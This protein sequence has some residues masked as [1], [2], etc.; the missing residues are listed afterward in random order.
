MLFLETRPLLSRLPSC[1]LFLRGNIEDINTAF[2]SS[3]WQ[4]R[5]YILAE[6]DGGDCKNIASKIVSGRNGVAEMETKVEKVAHREFTTGEW[7][8]TSTRRA[9]YATAD[10]TASVPLR[11]RRDTCVSRN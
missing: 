7:P 6:L 4:W 10:T 9:V 2:S 8:Y 11:I 3:T 1:F 5:G